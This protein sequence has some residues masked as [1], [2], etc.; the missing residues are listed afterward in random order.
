MAPKVPNFI[1]LTT[2]TTAVTRAGTAL[3]DPESGHRLELFDPKTRPVAVIW[4]D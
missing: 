3:I 4:D 2:A 1:V